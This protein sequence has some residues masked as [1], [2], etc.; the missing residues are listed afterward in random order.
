ME[1]G[2]DNTRISIQLDAFAARGLLA[3][4]EK[5][6]VYKLPFICRSALASNSSTLI[7]Q[8]QRGNFIFCNL[9]HNFRNLF[10]VRTKPLCVIQSCLAA[11]SA[12]LVSDPSHEDRGQALKKPGPSQL[13]YDCTS[14]MVAVELT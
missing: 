3:S 5:V 8:V 13:S 12:Q 10:E 14:P 11:F 4:Q 9:G 6:R 7:F 2:A 1:S